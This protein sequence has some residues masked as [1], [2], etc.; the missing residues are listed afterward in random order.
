MVNTIDNP[1]KKT[2]RDVMPLEFTGYTDT[3][4]F[5]FIDVE[6]VTEHMN[7]ARWIGPQKNVF[8]WVELANGFAVGW[9]ENPGRGWS[10]PVVK[11]TSKFNQ[12]ERS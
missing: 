2:L 6:V 9:N 7:D 1:K 11:I 10:F 4:A 3:K 5:K 12:P 8:F